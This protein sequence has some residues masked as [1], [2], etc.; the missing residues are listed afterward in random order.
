MR[1]PIFGYDVPAVISMELP[2]L[3]W[4][5]DLC[6]CYG[7]LDTSGAG[8]VIWCEPEARSERS[9]GADGPKGEVGVGPRFVLC[10]VES[11]PDKISSTVLF[12]SEDANAVFAE[13]LKLPK[14]VGLILDYAV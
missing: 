12:E 9:E 11:D 8:S 6:A 5:N 2:C 10:K 4:H 3:S 7:V 13:Y 14:T 1:D